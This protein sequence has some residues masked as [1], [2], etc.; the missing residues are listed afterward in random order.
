MRRKHE[1]KFWKLVKKRHD[2]DKKNYFPKLFRRLRK[3]LERS[4]KLIFWW[5][6]LLIH[7]ILILNYEEYILTARKKSSKPNQRLNCFFSERIDLTWKMLKSAE[8]FKTFKKRSATLRFWGFL[9]KF[10]MKLRSFGAKTK[11]VF[12]LNVYLVQFFPILTIIEDETDTVNENVVYRSFEPVLKSLFFDKMGWFL[13]QL[14]MSSSNSQKAT[15][16]LTFVQSAFRYLNSFQPKTLV[17]SWTLF[18]KN[19]Q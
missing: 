1:T 12:E 6:V 2:Q 9:E 10:F 8:I 5:S 16:F 13:F 14:A 15:Q 3:L 19:T 7:W 11:V 17:Y 4:K 18:I